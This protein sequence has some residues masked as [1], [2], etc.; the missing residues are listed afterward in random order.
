[1]SKRILSLVLTLC[2][3]VLAVPMAALPVM[4]EA[5]TVSFAVQESGK[6]GLNTDGV[7]VLTSTLEEK[8]IPS[9]TELAE[10]GLT[11]DQII[12]WYAYDKQSDS[13]VN[14]EAYYRGVYELTGDL[15]FYPITKSSYTQGF[16]NGWPTHQG[17]NQP[18]WTANVETNG[19]TI[20]AYRG[21]E[22]KTWIG[23]WAYGSYVGEV[24]TQFS[25]VGENKYA[26]FTTAAGQSVGCY[27]PND[28]NVYVSGSN[29][30]PDA[31]TAWVY[32]AVADG[33]VEITIPA[34]N[35]D[36]M[37]MA[38]AQ[39]GSYVWPEA[40]K[41]G[42]ANA[43]A[44]ARA[45]WA[46]INK[47]ALM[48][49]TYKAENITATFTVDVKA[50]DQIHFIMARTV[51]AGDTPNFYP[52]VNYTSITKVP[53]APMPE[54]QPLV[55][56]AVQESGKAALNT[57]GIVVFESTAELAMLPNDRDLAGTGLTTDQILGWYR[58]DKALDTFL[59]VEA[60]YQG[61]YELEEDLFF[62]PIT[63][64][65]YTQGYAEGWTATC[66]GANQPIWTATQGEGG[67]FPGSELKTWVGG[68]AYGAYAG[69]QFNLFNTIGDNKY[70][71]LM[72]P[73][74]QNG[75]AY[76]SW[77]GD[78]WVTQANTDNVTTMVYYAVADGTVTITLPGINRAN[79]VG[80]VAKNGSYVWPEAIKDG[81]A[82]G[83]AADA[84]K[85]SWGEI[86]YIGN[87]RKNILYQEAN[88]TT[89]FTLDVK[90]GDKLHF[91]LAKTDGADTPYY[92]PTVAYTEISNV[93]VILPEQIV[94]P[95]ATVVPSI[96]DT[97]GLKFDVKLPGALEGGILINGEE[98]TSISLAPQDAD[99]DITVKTFVVVSDELT[100][101]GEE[102]TITFNGLLQTYVD[103]VNTPE[104]VKNMAKA[105]LDYTA[106]YAAFFGEG[107]APTV[108]AFDA[109]G[110][111]KII[112]AVNYT[113]DNEVKI[114]GLSLLVNEKVNI[115]LVTYDLPA[116]AKIQVASD[117][118]FTTIL[119][120]GK[121]AMTATEDGTG[122]K[123]I[124]DGISIY[125]WDTMYFFRIVDAE[126]N[127]ISDTVQ[128]SVF[129]YCARMN[130]KDNAKL[131]ALVN[132]VM[133]LYSTLP[134]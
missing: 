58:Y 41:G 127:V 37:I 39:N 77:H 40:V 110:V 15:I 21:S 55:K 78:L 10:A 98:A 122:Y 83:A 24:F 22:I 93:P 26:L 126:G 44:D 84:N 121:D 31:A 42:K 13:F 97:L 70:A 60:Y 88:I 132:A 105:A 34:T 62:Y 51:A 20:T 32:Y 43:S 71:L 102:I 89:T 8:K 14:V 19:S 67:T 101:Y 35:R 9:D 46:V 69:D 103:D 95:S 86:K 57:D 45:D 120:E 85:A 23:G 133:N 96:G 68:W 87:G 27:Y 134:Q 73:A 129:T 30:N 92:Y 130:D 113:G 29:D 12:G 94:A 33:T 50:G 63:K 81:K 1:M 54:D 116:G 117:K 131:T 18:I 125:N 74:G 118:A 49:Q 91:M 64:S 3:L 123:Y 48:S 5:P 114:S 7:I 72:T 59:S 124:M 76:Y 90:A 119:N 65:S 104:N 52:T 115:K 75:G 107:D 11:A 61:Y 111:N 79:I 2:M 82:T 53:V 17:A 6:S 109:S 80:A 4:A 38:V 56:F 99:K 36:N 108:P 100:I 128:Y 112:G 106:A 16:A 47:A 66:G 28:G 25:A